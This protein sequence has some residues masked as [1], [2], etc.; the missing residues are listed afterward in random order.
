MNVFYLDDIFRTNKEIDKVKM[1]I[2][3]YSSH[4]ITIKCRDRNSSD[5][6]YFASDLSNISNQ[7]E[8]D[9]FH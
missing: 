1:E 3:F 8:K 9:H 5:L 7:T 2:P 6:K 4:S